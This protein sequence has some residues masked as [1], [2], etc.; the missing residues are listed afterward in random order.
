MTTRARTA[1][2]TALL[3]V[4]ATWPA[5]GLAESVSYYPQVVGPPQRVVTGTLIEMGFGMK[6]GGLTVRLAN[7]RVINIYLAKPPFRIDG[8]RIDCPIPPQ[9]G[10][11]RDSD[12]CRVWPSSVVI[13]KTRVNVPVWAGSR[14]GKP[15]L[16]AREFRTVK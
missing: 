12:N 15:T 9:G 8:R 2:A 6:S 13:G 1:A 5:I 14:D 11:S 3:L 16:I 10:L 4:P 7:G